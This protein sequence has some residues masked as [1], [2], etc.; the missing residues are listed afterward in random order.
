MV[1][2][3]GK[4]IAGILQERLQQLA[5][6]ELPESQGGFCKGRGCTDVIFVVHQLVEKM[7][8]HQT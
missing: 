2:V 8:E 4:V 3:V 1:D 6:V 7:W 5:E